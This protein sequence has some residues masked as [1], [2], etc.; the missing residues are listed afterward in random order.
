MA[1]PV[2]GVAG[3][4]GYAPAY[5]AADP[6]TVAASSSGY[7]NVYEALQG[8]GLTDF[9]ALADSSRLSPLLK[10]A[11]IPSTVFVPSN[12]AVAQAL[13][14]MQMD[15]QAIAGNKTV[16]TYISF[17]HVVPGRV[18]S[19][20]ELQEMGASGKGEVLPTMR[21]YDLEASVDPSTGNVVLV[22]GTEARLVPGRTNIKAGNST[23]HVIDY[24]LLPQ[25]TRD[26]AGLKTRAV[27]KRFR[28]VAEA[29]VNTPQLSSTARA[30]ANDP[31]LASVLSSPNLVST[32][33]APNNA[34]WA[35]LAKTNSPLLNNAAWIKDSVAYSVATNRALSQD[36]LRN[37]GPGSTL[38]TL[39]GA[40]LVV[41][42]MST[43]A[44]QALVGT[45]DVR[46]MAQEAG[47]LMGGM[48]A[49]AVALMMSSDSGMQSVGVVGQPLVAG[50]SIVHE[51]DG[52][53]VPKAVATQ[54]QAIEAER[55]KQ[56]EAKAQAA[57]MLAAEVARNATA[58]AAKS[59]AGEGVAASVVAV[60]AAF[61]AML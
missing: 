33:F 37:L 26:E 56:A 28:T 16:V 46:P 54:V 49:G 59:G 40:P 27:A 53:L 19:E 61:A 57:A 30:A 10:N 4:A 14:D 6:A 5:A 21:G 22:G 13:S 39:S 17:Y 42:Q 12:Q 35:N 3:G 15:A 29:L 7:R 50:R 45:G 60:A 47:E 18:F 52:V 38:S 2:G 25:D 8:E 43:A 51:V 44:E 32:V 34:A 36:E 24:L 41:G 48:P 9:Q 1:A 55:K 31:Q 58:K 11:S 20:A 23:V